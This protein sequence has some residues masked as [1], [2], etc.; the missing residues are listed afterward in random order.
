MNEDLGLNPSNP[1][2][3]LL[4][5][6]S[7]HNMQARKDNSSPSIGTPPDWSSLSSMWPPEDKMDDMSQFTSMDL[8]IGIGISR[9]IQSM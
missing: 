4:H 9:G 7:Q 1:L 3:L 5:N 8:G 2:N 6:H